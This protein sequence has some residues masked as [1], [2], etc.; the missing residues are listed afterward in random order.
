M[1]AP[2]GDEEKDDEGDGDDQKG[3]EVPRLR[4]V[5]R[6]EGMDGALRATTGTLEACEGEED[7]AGEK[8]G[9]R[10]NKGIEQCQCRYGDGTENQSKPAG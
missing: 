10:I 7:A 5:P 4:E 9:S 1:L 3:I 8:M 2:R 6:E